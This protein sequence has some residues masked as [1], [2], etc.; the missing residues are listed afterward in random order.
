[1]YMPMD[2]QVCVCIHS[3]AHKHSHTP[4]RPGAPEAPPLL[5]YPTNPSPPAAPAHPRA[6]FLS[7]LPSPG[8]NPR[9][10]VLRVTALNHCVRTTSGGRIRREGEIAVK[11]SEFWVGS[12][13]R[14]TI[15]NGGAANRVCG[16][17]VGPAATLIT[18]FYHC[19]PVREGG[20]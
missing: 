17:A 12:W 4:L 13:N 3:C 14:K 7:I 6:P 5:I 8:T 2:T 19:V 1:M 20:N 15:L 16:S 9:D 18:K 11:R 10:R